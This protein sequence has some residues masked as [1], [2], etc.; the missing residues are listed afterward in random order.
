MSQMGKVMGWTNSWGPVRAVEV[1]H[2]GLL[3]IQNTRQLETPHCATALI[4]ISRH[5]YLLY[6]LGTDSSLPL[7]RTNLCKPCLNQRLVGLG[8]T[9]GIARSRGAR[10]ARS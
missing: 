6:H 1:C 7:L 8:F 10:P 4:L 9:N 3:M 2:S 5:M